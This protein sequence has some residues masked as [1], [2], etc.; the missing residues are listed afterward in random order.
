MAHSRDVSPIAAVVVAVVVA[1]ATSA[2]AG[3]PAAAS[4]PP[5]PSALATAALGRAAAA[6]KALDWTA[7]VAALDDASSVARGQMPLMVR[8]AVPTLGP[9][10]GLHIYERLPAGDVVPGRTLNVYLEVDGVGSTPEADGR[11]RHDLDVSGRFFSTGD[12]GALELLGE[13]NLGRHTVT[14]WQKLP[15]QPVGVDVVLGDAPAGA[16]AVDIVVTDRAT[17]QTA[18]RQVPFRLR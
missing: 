3:A 14:A 6:I 4:A 13:K 2:V 12:S 16:Y 5:T 15:L 18:H 7:V 10:R 1:L 17:G 8:T 9:H 11:F